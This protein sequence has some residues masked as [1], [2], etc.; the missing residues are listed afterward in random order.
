MSHEWRSVVGYEGL[1]E[2]SSDGRVRSIAS[3]TQWS[4][5]RDYGGRELKQA[6]K[7]N[8]YRQ[9][10]LFR[11]GK[12]E[13]ALVHTLVLEAFVGPRPQ[14]A[15]ACHGDGNRANNLVINLRWDTVKA[16]HSDK[17]KHGTVL[18]GEKHGRAKITEES[19]QV[20]LTS[21]KPS[22]AIAA[23][24]GMSSRQVRYWRKQY[25]WTKGKRGDPRI[26]DCS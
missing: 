3:S 22:N 17:I 21:A 26:V 1:Y 19:L 8:G 4:R 20:I 15:Q 10:T 9:V 16:N 24:V 11:K 25:G 23:G 13:S 12:G 18:R 6:T 5:W 14:G 2:L 7:R